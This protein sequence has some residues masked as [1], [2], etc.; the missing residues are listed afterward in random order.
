[1]GL[2]DSLAKAKETSRKGSV[3]F[4]CKLLPE[5]DDEDRESLTSALKDVTVYATVIGK[6]LRA[7][8]YKV[9]DDCVQ[10]HRRGGCVGR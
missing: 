3:C 1:V 2:A 9:A 10:R 4:I 8:G 6:A 5:L 7:E